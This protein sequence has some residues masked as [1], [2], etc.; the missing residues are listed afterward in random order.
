MGAMLL[1]DG[2]Y[3]EPIMMLKLYLQ[4]YQDDIRTA[5]VVKRLKW[6]DYWSGSCTATQFV[7]C[8]NM[9]AKLREALLEQYRMRSGRMYSRGI[10]ATEEEDSMYPAYTVK[11]LL[12]KYPHSF[13]DPAHLNRM[14]L[15]IT[16]A[17]AIA[18]S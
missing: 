16:W 13:I 4:W 2:A 1:D 11:T 9:V 18:A 6:A 7:V 15:V 14:R 8:D 17:A 10:A 3:S 12:E 5:S